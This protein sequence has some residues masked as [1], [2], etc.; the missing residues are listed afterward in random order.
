MDDWHCWHIPLHLP[1]NNWAVQGQIKMG[2]DT[3]KTWRLQ[4]YKKYKENNLVS[5]DIVHQFYSGKKCHTGLEMESHMIFW[6]GQKVVE[7]DKKLFSALHLYIPKIESSQMDG[8]VALKITQNKTNR[9]KTC[10]IFERSKWQCVTFCTRLK[11]SKRFCKVLITLKK[12]CKSFYK[13]FLKIAPRHGFS[14]VENFVQIRSAVVEIEIH[15]WTDTHTEH[16]QYRDLSH[17]NH[18]WILFISHTICWIWACKE[19][20]IELDGA[21]YRRFI[22]WSWSKGR[23]IDI[24]NIIT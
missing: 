17:Y 12:F 14:F 20:W 6:W 5:V 3:W 15:M 18:E 11:L 21:G 9:V 23:K 16:S 10:V 24:K 13:C 7:M 1:P 2:L 22:L 19:I 4:S 8:D